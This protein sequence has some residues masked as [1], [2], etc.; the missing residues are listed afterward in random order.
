[1]YTQK[2]QTAAILQNLQ[3]S[4]YYTVIEENDSEAHTTGQIPAKEQGL[5]VPVPAPVPQ[6]KEKDTTSKCE[7]TPEGPLIPGPIPEE[8][9]KQQPNKDISAAETVGPK[10]SRKRKRGRGKSKGKKTTKKARSS[11]LP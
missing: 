1:M 4:G 10:L 7:T 3:R 8:G 5:P 9:E 6:P 2:T 11:N